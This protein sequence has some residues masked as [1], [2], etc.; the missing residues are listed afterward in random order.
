MSRTRAPAPTMS[1][2][3]ASL[4]RFA[5]P[6]SR[7]TG[8]KNAPMSRPSSFVCVRKPSWP[9]LMS[10]WEYATRLPWRSIA[11]A[12]ARLWP[13]LKSQSPEMETMSSREVMRRQTSSSEPYLTAAS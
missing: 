13:S 6:T 2:M 3:G 8:E 12:R 10:R 9:T 11:A 5:G 4:R 7:G 1:T